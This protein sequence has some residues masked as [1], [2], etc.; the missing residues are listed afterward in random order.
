MRGIPVILDRDLPNMASHA[1]PGECGFSVY[2]DVLVRWDEDRD[3]RVLDFIDDLPPALRKNLAVVQEHEAS[4]SLRWKG[5][6]PT[7]FEEG[8]LVEVGDDTWE[9]V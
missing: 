6:V 9:I 2:Q 7:G 8:V 5:R 3:P 4:L 1:D